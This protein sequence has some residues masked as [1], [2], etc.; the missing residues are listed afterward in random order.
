MSQQDR[1]SR[2]VGALGICYIKMCEV[3]SCACLKRPSRHAMP[4]E[5]PEIEKFKLA[6]PVR[7]SYHIQ[8]EACLPPLPQDR[9]H[10]RKPLGLHHCSNHLAYF[11]SAFVSGTAALCAEVQAP[12]SF[13]NSRSSLTA[14]TGHFQATEFFFCSSVYNKEMLSRKRGGSMIG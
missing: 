12:V 1:F 7:R 4:R 10:D 11:I 2:R 14:L 5:V 6:I 3:S 8:A 9:L 13:C